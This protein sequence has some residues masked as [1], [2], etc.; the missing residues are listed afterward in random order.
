M[1]SVVLIGSMGIGSRDRRAA[2]KN[3]PTWTPALSS[4]TSR[5]RA[6]IEQGNQV[7]LGHPRSPPDARDG[8][9]LLLQDSVSNRLSSSHN[10]CSPLLS[11]HLRT[12]SL[13]QICSSFVCPVLR[14]IDSLPYFQS[15]ELPPPGLNSSC[16]ICF[17]HP[18][19]LSAK[20]RF[21]HRR[22]SP[23]SASHTLVELDG[24][25][26]FVLFIRA[27]WTTLAVEI[28]TRFSRSADPCTHIYAV[29]SRA[30]TRS[31]AGVFLV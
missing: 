16:D 29:V 12:A 15:T 17:A 28:A 2:V 19:L 26:G 20:P 22:S 18:R 13:L 1:Y 30:L 7:W 21:F 14:K 24:D 4:G 3:P 23:G 5:R 6:G 31:P 9:L 27:F 8:R 10:F 25:I 11:S